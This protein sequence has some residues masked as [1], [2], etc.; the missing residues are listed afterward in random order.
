MAFDP[1]SGALGIAGLG[2]QLYG[3]YEASQDAKKEAGIEKQMVGVEEQQDK[4]RQQAM[5]L[6]A[7]RQQ[8]EQVRLGQRARA[9]ALNT[10][11]NQGAQFGSALG[12]AYGGISGQIGTNQTG[13]SQNLAFGENMFALNSSL[14]QLKMQKADVQSQMYSD[15]GLASLGGSLMGMGK[16]FGGGSSG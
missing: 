1:L 9:M 2:L 14:D 6:S 7:S 15:Q 4:V 5:E 13:I 10:T 3:S 12:G 16:I 11:T 8:L